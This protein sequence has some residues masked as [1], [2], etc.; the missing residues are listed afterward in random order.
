MTG[1]KI[2]VS[3]C[4]QLVHD[5]INIITANARADHTDSFSLVGTCNGME[6][7]TL[8]VALYFFKMRSYQRH[9][10]WIAYQNDL[11]GQLFGLDM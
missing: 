8:Y 3:Q 7:S 11:V 9:A 1:G 6:F 10:A 2:N 5:N 4:I